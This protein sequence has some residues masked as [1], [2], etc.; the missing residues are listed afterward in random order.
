MSGTPPVM[1]LVST[2]IGFVSFALTILIWLHSFWNAFQTVAGARSQIQ[3]EL[4]LLRQRL[5]EEAEYLRMLR[6]R[7]RP[8]SERHRSE[9]KYRGGRDRD[10][11]E[12]GGGAH[13]RVRGQPKKDIY[14]D[15]GPI[16]VLW[17]AVKDLIKDFKM[18]EQPFLVIPGHTDTEKG[19]KEL[20]WSY[21]ALRQNYQCD[22]P[23]RL[24]WLKY[25]H[26]VTDVS[27][28]LEKIQTHR[29]AIEATRG[30]LLI[31]DT[32]GL[33]RECHERVMDVE[34]RVRVIEDRVLGFRVVRASG[35]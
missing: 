15:G 29:A 24:I 4:S 18:Y 22:L 30:R 34:D 13:D 11:D 8:P 20:E 21:G 31:T 23:Q 12:K 14:H 32:M 25:R 1:G 35:L 5:Y 27:T 7:E 17:D 16:R 28:R 2:I 19:E 9:D 10:A 26:H 3:D 6:R 33:V